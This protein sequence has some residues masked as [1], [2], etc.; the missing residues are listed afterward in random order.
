MIKVYNKNMKIIYVSER[1]SSYAKN[2]VEHD[3][4]KL[5]EK[6]LALGASGAKTVDVASIRTGAWTRWKC[7]FGCPNYG[8]TLCCPPFVPDYAATQRFLQEFIR[9]IIIQYTFPLNGVAVENFAAADLSMSNGLL[10]ILLNLEREAFLQNH[11]KAFA[12]KAGRCRLCK[13]CNLKQCVNP[14][15]ARPSL[16]ACE[17]MLW[18]W[19]MIMVIRRKFCRRRFL[20]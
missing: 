4:H 11:Y 2:C 5:V 10:E 9:G 15:K 14:T 1:R 19:L 3:L 20:S 12:L 6:A 16:E 17:L 8:K 18:L 7:Q 13:E